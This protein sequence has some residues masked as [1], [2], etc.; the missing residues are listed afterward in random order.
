MGRI[1]Y[2]ADPTGKMDSTAAFQQALKVALARGDASNN[3]LSNGIKDCGMCL[4]F[5]IPI[6]TQ[7]YVSHVHNRRSH[8]IFGWR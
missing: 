2:G 1:N 3:S 8:N 5:S 6:N 7:L 4:I